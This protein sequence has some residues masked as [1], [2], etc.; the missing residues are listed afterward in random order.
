MDSMALPDLLLHGMVVAMNNI[1]VSMWA[2]SL[3]SHASTDFGWMDGKQ[4]RRL[5]PLPS[6]EALFAWIVIGVI[7]HQE[8]TKRMTDY[9]LV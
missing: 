7:G 6:L 1:H 4:E 8:L 9:C 3:F 2:A 5:Y